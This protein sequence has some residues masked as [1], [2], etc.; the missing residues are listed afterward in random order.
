MLTG[1]LRAGPESSPTEWFDTKTGDQV[2]CVEAPAFSVASNPKRHVGPTNLLP[3]TV[4]DWM[5]RLGL[6]SRQ[7]FLKRFR[8]SAV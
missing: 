3:T 8:A 5:N 4:G 6:Q 2:Y 1:K 7:K